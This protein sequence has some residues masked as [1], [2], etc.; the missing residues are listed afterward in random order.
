MPDQR[1]NP[2]VGHPTAQLGK[3]QSAGWVPPILRG[4]R[5]SSRTE[6]RVQPAPAA[7]P[8]LVLRPRS[9]TPS[10]GAPLYKASTRVHAIHASGHS[11]RL[12]PPRWN[13]WPLGLSLRLPHPADQE[14]TTHARGGSRPS[15]TGPETT[16]YDISRASNPACS[17]DCVRP[18]VAPSIRHSRSRRDGDASGSAGSRPKWGACVCPC[19]GRKPNGQAPHGSA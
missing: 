12:R 10:C 6:G 19:A 13:G 1:Q 3:E 7:L 4:R 16:L 5:C 2:L 8:R 15:S 17:L 14:P 11:P 9:N 18:R